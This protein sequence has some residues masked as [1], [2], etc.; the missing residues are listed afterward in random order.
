MH[1][2]FIEKNDKGYKDFFLCKICHDFSSDEPYYAPEF[3]YWEVLE[4]N[5]L[6]GEIISW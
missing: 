4:A 1:M 3:F 5:G 6:V 2:F